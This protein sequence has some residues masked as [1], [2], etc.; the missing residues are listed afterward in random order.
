MV[1][2]G[3]DGCSLRTREEDEVLSRNLEEGERRYKGW[4]AITEAMNDLVGGEGGVVNGEEAL[5]SWTAGVFRLVGLL[6]PYGV[7]IL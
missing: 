3:V 2:N 7:V 6:G 5:S 1:F 4:K